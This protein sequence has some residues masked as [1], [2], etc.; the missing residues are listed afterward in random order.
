MPFEVY[1]DGIDLVIFE[2]FGSGAAALHLQDEVERNELM[3]DEAY[4]HR[5]RKDYERK[6]GIRVWQRDFYRRRHRRLP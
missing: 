6:L 4:R 5:F 2:E 3:Q 1:A